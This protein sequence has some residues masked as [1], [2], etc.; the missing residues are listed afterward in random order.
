[1]YMHKYI[2]QSEFS[3]LVFYLTVPVVYLIWFRVP[4][5]SALG[6]RISVAYTSPSTPDFQSIVKVLPADL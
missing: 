2:G 3:D 6:V 1:M 4:I 5:R